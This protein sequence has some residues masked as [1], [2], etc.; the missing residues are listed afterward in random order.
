MAPIA[1]HPHAPAPKIEYANLLVL[2]ELIR[3]ASGTINAEHAE[4]MRARTGISVGAATIRRAVNILG[5]T[6]KNRSSS[7]GKPMPRNLGI[8]V[9]AG[10]PGNGR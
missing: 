8:F 7:R 6:P 2:E 1:D 3:E 10:E 9:R 4:R 5:W